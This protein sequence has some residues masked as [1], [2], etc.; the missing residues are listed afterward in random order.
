MQRRW[1][2]GLRARPVKASPSAKRKVLLTQDK[3]FI[4]PKS[5]T[6]K[7]KKRDETKAEN[8]DPK[9]TRTDPA[10]ALSRPDPTRLEPTDPPRA[11]R[12]PST[13][14]RVAAAHLHHAAGRH[15]TTPRHAAGQQQR[16]GSTLT[17]P[18]SP[19]L[20]V[21]TYVHV[22]TSLPY[23]SGLVVIYQG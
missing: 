20:A 18:P 7:C 4:V 17:R 16:F 10:F 13:A 19:L 11:R 2:F 15:C 1:T 9:V 5:Q 8:L 23:F 12:T 14:L 21:R 3:V 22:L 6:T